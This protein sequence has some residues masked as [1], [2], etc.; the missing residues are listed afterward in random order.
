MTPKKAGEA[1][2]RSE[3]Q[4]RRAIEDAPIPIIM[5]AED[6]EVLQLSRTWTDLT[7][8]TIN[9]VPD[10]DTW[11]T[12]SAYGQGADDVR[13]HMHALFAGKKKSIGVEFPVK[14]IDGST[15]HW[16]FSASSPGTLLDGRRFI[17]GMAVDITER[18]KAEE[19][20]SFRNKQ[21]EDLQSELEAKAAE[22][23]EYANRMEELAEERALKLRDAERLAA[24]GA[25]AGM[26]GHDIRNPLQS[27]S[28]DIYLALQDLIDLPDSEQK[29]NIKNSL[30]G[31]NESVDY[32][33][34]I[35]QDLQDFARPVKPALKEVELQPLFEDI[36]F[37]NHNLPRKVVASCKVDADASRI[38]VDP[39]LLRRIVGNLV[40]N[41]GQAMPE[42]GRLR[43][44]ARRDGGEVVIEVQDTGVGI[45]EEVKP[46]LFTPLFT[47][48]S[49]GQGFG[50]AVVKRMTEAMSG[51]VAFESEEGKGTKFIVRLPQKEMI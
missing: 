12:K 44:Q 8:Y 46:R 38:I 48:R 17:I 21:L 29:Q 2:R 24:I 40:S 39:E 14:A 33:N 16:S 42:G 30:E 35:V 26:V 1:L 3:E 4:L 41:A 11:L 34:K 32:I 37:R 6:G 15:R 23:E 22:V 9:D 19:E 50:L 13:D 7:G 18:K 43:V 51:T 5:Q 45:S 36:L 31:V 49:K 27:I 47:T 25:T 10:F 28:G 20:L